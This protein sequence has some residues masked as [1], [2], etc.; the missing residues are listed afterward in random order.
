MEILLNRNKVGHLTAKGRVNKKS[1]LFLIDTAASNTI[2][3]SALA[4]TLELNLKETSEK[5]GGLG[6]SDMP[7]KKIQNLE[8]EINGK[9]IAAEK[10]A[11]EQK[12]QQEAEKAAA[13]RAAP[14]AGTPNPGSAQEYALTA[15]QNY[16]WGGDEYNCL[17]SLWNKESGWNVYAH[18]KSSGAYGIPQALPGD[19]MGS[20]GADWATNHVTQINW[21]LGYIAN[22]YGTPCAAWGHSQQTGWY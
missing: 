8:I 21:G 18:N 9:M 6:T 2:I 7:I 3:D 13:S 5:G 14:A 20:A 10:A 11:A 12:A 1:L 19:K 16:G 22:R 4:A 17:V 15:I